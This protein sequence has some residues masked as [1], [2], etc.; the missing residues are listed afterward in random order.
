MSPPR[1]L[2]I[3]AKR[4]IFI[5]FVCVLLYLTLVTRN[6]DSF[7]IES[8]SIVGQNT[9]G[10]PQKDDL[11]RIEIGYRGPKE[12]KEKLREQQ[13][14]IEILLK[15][16]AS[17]AKAIELLQKL[18]GS[19]DKIDGEGFNDKRREDETKTEKLDNSQP[20]ALPTRKSQ[21]PS[22]S[23]D[24]L[25]KSKE[26]AIQSKPGTVPVSSSKTTDKTLSVDGERKIIRLPSSF[27]S[28]KEMV[29]FMRK[30]GRKLSLSRKN[31]RN[32]LVLLNQRW[33]SG[34]MDE[35]YYQRIDDVEKPPS[36]ENEC[37]DWT[38]DAAEY[39]V[40]YKPVKRYQDGNCSYPTNETVKRII[41]P[42]KKVV[43]KGC[44]R[45]KACH[46][47]AYYD[48]K[49]GLRRN[50]PPCCR[51]HLLEML[52]NIDRELTLRNITY[53][54]ADGAVIGWYRNQKLV[55]YDRDIDMY[56]DG[57]YFKTRIWEEVF[58]NLTTKFGYDYEQTEDYKYRLRYSKI[59]G[60]QVDI[61]PY[62]NIKLR[63][64]YGELAPGEW[65]TFVYHAGTTAMRVDEFFPPIRTTIEG[66]P[67]SVPRD[68][69][70]YLNKNYGP[71]PD[72]WL[73]E[74]TCKTFKSY[75]C[76]T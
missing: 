55:P 34:G 49:R 41:T 12:L 22:Q 48:V 56:V 31:S 60:L 19:N 57:T 30:Q 27:K 28:H 17:Y 47:N 54:V 64:Q 6:R 46:E 11:T 71:T 23:E 32:K 14:T 18:R 44:T 33:N 59:N 69:V 37:Y 35:D 66:V 67:C 73:P 40:V 43:W 51:D 74:L 7:L 9:F 75:N 3:I 29:A 10:H 38:Y 52:R 21:Q 76:H 62:F 61:W 70:K 42:N 15:T 58:G 65:I 20:A 13:K 72:H 2:R 1:L 50:V 16:K 24:I 4:I 25:N 68:T 26:G 53:T 36:G 8:N 63:T 45:H 5:I 39:T